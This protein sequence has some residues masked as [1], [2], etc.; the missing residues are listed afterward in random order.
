MSRHICL[1]QVAPLGLV[2]AIV[3]L[4]AASRASAQDP[5][6]IEVYGYETAPRSTWEL[7]GHLN[8][9]AIGTSVADG[10][11]APTARQGHLALE[12]TRGLTD[13]W[14]VAAYVLSAHRPGLG[15]EYAGA[16]V[17]SRI[18][19][20]ESWRL[21]VDVSVGAELEFSRAAYD[22]NAAGLEIR[23]IFEKRIGRVQLDLNPVLERGL[24]ERGTGRDA[25]WEFEPSA[26]VGVEVSRAVGLSVEYYGKT[27]L[28]DHSLPSGEQVHQIYPGVD[29]K[30]GDDFVINIG[31]G[32]GTTPA[33]SRLVVKS[34]F[35]VPLGR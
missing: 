22:E 8:Y 10:T 17:R 32:F 28:F 3:A 4:F 35:E 1:R 18:R 33:G 25:E 34:R 2:L 29:L 30:L 23:P 11:V 27:G 13:H 20:P 12:L 6:E 26:R 19:L 9:T 14:E 16:R 21:P 24:R 5:F 7:D 15:L 31:V